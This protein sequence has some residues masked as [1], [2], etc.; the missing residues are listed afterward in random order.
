MEA[1][2]FVL[3]FDGGTGGRDLAFAEEDGVGDG[4]VDPAVGG[5]LLGDLSV[6][7]DSDGGGVGL[8]AEEEL[9]AVA[10]GDGSDLGES[11]GPVV[12]ADGFVDAAELFCGFDVAGG[13]VSVSCGGVSAAA[14][15]GSDDGGKA[16]QVEVAEAFEVFEEGDIEVDGLRG[17]IFFVGDDDD[18]EGGFRAI[19]VF[20]AVCVGGSG[21]SE[22]FVSGFEAFFGGVASGTDAGVCGEGGFGVGG[23]LCDDAG[24][25]ACAKASAAG[26]A[27]GA[28]ALDGGP[29]GLAGGVCGGDEDLVVD[30]EAD[31]PCDEGLEVG[32]QV[33]LFFVHGAGVVDDDEDIGFGLTELAEHVFLI[34]GVDAFAGERDREG[35]LSLDVVFDFEGTEVDVEVGRFVACFDDDVVARGEGFGECGDA[36]QLELARGALSEGDFADGDAGATARCTEVKD[37][38]VAIRSGA[39]D[40]GG[41][42]VHLRGDDFE[43]EV[44][45]SAVEGDLE[46]WILAVVAGD[47]EFALVSRD[48]LRG[49]VVDIESA[50]F[51]RGDDDGIGE[52]RIEGKGGVVGGV[53]AFD[54]DGFGLFDDAVAVPFFVGDLDGESAAATD[55]SEGELKLRRSGFEF[56]FEFAGDL[57]VEGEFDGGFVG[58]AAGDDEVIGVGIFVFGI[59]AEQELDQAVGSDGLAIG[60]CGDEGVGSAFFEGDL[61]DDTAFVADVVDGDALGAGSGELDTEFGVGV[62]FEVASARR[63]LELDGCAGEVSCVAFDFD[64]AAV[65]DI[66][67]GCV[68][69]GD[70]FFLFGFDLEGC[71]DGR[72]VDAEVKAAVAV[73]FDFVDFEGKV[74]VGADEESTGGGFAFGGEGEEQGGSA[75]LGGG[76]A[77]FFAAE[78]VILAGQAVVDAAAGVV[79]LAIAVVRDELDEWDGGDTDD[80]DPAAVGVVFGGDVGKEFEFALVF[81]GGIIGGVV[82]DLEGDSGLFGFDGEGET[83]FK[84]LEVTIGAFFFGVYDFTDGEVGVATVGDGAV[85]GFGLAFLDGA[86]VEGFS[87]IKER[88]SGEDLVIEADDEKAG[89][90]DVICVGGDVDAGEEVAGLLGEELDF[91]GDGVVEAGFEGEGHLRF[92][93]DREDL[94]LV[95][96][97][98]EF[99]DT[100]VD[101]AFVVEEKFFGA[102]LSDLDVGEDHLVVVEVG[103]EFTDAGGGGFTAGT[104]GGGGGSDQQGKKSHIDQND[105]FGTVHSIFLHRMWGSVL[106]GLCGC[107]LFGCLCCRFVAFVSGVCCRVGNASQVRQTQI[108]QEDAS[109]RTGWENFFTPML[110]FW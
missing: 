30:V 66:I 88:F 19:E 71:G 35:G 5:A 69:D 64:E 53:G 101:L 17:V 61:V 75:A 38:D 45:R 102:G 74:A 58:V 29:L 76:Q 41:T 59:E 99:G 44:A 84:D 82:G 87:A 70:Q 85:E 108:G 56:A 21:G 42:E 92:V 46:E 79:V 91:D 95:A 36:A 52:L 96:I 57:A 81:G 51:A 47:L 34:G 14:G 23:G 73:E 65:S 7:F 31:G 33:G 2:G 6:D 105:S 27:G 78:G 94:A 25:R 98:G 100:D 55:G 62:D 93:D 26:D 15:C 86:E 103:G 83:G 3:D 106:S 90:I 18:G 63:G 12:V 109:R 13:V 54:H 1:D 104:S 77:E 22:C 16:D 8:S 60:L 49:S 11:A 37:I 39:S 20:V 4:V 28:V 9:L 40:F 48:A 50:A 43:A 72:A 80:F 89:F 24:G 110:F 68:F 107:R 32:G 97:D 67:G 10:E